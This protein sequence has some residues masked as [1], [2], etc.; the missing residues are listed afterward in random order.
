MTEL[1]QRHPRI[2]YPAYLAYVRTLPCLAC[3]KAPPSDPAHL[4]SAARRYGKR[5]TGMQEKSDD[6]WALPLCRADH[7]AQHRA[8]ELEWWAGQGIPD[9]FAA[10]LTLYENR[11]AMPPPPEPKPFA[12]RVVK[13]RKPRAERKAIVGRSAFPAGRKL[14]SRK[15]LRRGT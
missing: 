5:L 13:P 3:R 10:A 11:P 7:D 1:A 9:P 14:Q 12:A 4:R 15:D 2:E 6:K 8:N